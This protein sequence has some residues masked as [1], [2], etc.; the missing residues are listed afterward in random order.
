MQSSSEGN[1]TFNRGFAVRSC[2]LTIFPCHLVSFCIWRGVK[3]KETCD[4]KAV[5][6]DLLYS[7]IL[8]FIQVCVLTFL[9]FDCNLELWYDLNKEFLV[10]LYFPIPACSDRKPTW[11]SWTWWLEKLAWCGVT[12]KPSTEKRV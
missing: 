12:W 5:I 10:L 3:K 7:N 4:K 2:M 1:S 9:S 8:N 6:W 11:R